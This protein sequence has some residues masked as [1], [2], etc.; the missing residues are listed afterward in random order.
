MIADL[1]D[2]NFFKA[3]GKGVNFSFN[4]RQPPLIRNVL[5]CRHP[6][7]LALSQNFVHLEPH[8]QHGQQQGTDFFDHARRQIGSRDIMQ[9]DR[10]QQLPKK[11][12]GEHPPQERAPEPQPG[13]RSAVDLGL[14]DARLRLSTGGPIRKNLVQRLAAQAEQGLDQAELAQSPEQSPSIRRRALYC[15][16]PYFSSC[17]ALLQS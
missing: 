16:K 12:D 4:P 13:G 15:V 5:R 14:V 3:Q 9:D 11:G 8:T 1:R 17:V 6:S 7:P 10:A 2:K